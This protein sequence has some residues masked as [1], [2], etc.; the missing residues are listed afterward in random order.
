MKAEYAQ[1]IKELGY[2]LEVRRVPCSSAGR[3]PCHVFT[4]QCGSTRSRCTPL[5]MRRELCFVS[6]V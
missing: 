5:Q 3:A 6:F 2:T 1:A 4:P